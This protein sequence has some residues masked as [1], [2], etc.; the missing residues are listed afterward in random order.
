MKDRP[1]RFWERSFLNK[2]TRME[3]CLFEIAKDGKSF[4]GTDR[5]WAQNRRLYMSP[6]E[7]PLYGE[8]RLECGTISMKGENA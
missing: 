3:S 1:R 8:K 4:L 5:V 2:K 6:K 7:L